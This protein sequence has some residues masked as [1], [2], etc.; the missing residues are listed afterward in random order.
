MSGS[1]ERKQFQ[2][3]ENLGEYRNIFNKKKVKLQRANGGCLGTD[4]RRR[5]CK[6]AKIHGELLKSL[7]PWESE[8]GNPAELKLCNH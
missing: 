8:W 4:S 6:A 5:T 2:K 1:F 3:T 7:D